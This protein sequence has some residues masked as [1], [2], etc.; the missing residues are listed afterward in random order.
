MKKKG[1]TKKAEKAKKG[2]AKRRRNSK[3][4]PTC[5]SSSMRSVPLDFGNG[6]QAGKERWKPTA[7]DIEECEKAL[8]DARKANPLLDAFLGFLKSAGFNMS[9]IRAV[10]MIPEPARKTPRQTTGGKGGKRG[11]K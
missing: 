8:K 5:G 11:K 4:W 2:T 9:G 3:R 6:Y 1:T 10:Y 7:A